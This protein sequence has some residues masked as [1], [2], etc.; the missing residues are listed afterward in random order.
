[1]TKEE[2]QKLVEKS[3]RLTSKITQAVQM[4]DRAIIVTEGKHALLERK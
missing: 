2:Q 3:L 1:M 4:I